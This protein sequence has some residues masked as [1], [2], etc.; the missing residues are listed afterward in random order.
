M[1]HMTQV[2]GVWF[3]KDNKYVHK[4]FSRYYADF[5]KFAE[6]VDKKMANSRD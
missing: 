5:P 6:V 2:A 1:P 4:L 3:H